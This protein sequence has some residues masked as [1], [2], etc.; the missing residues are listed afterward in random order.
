M[1]TASSIMEKLKTQLEGNANLSYVS[2]VF[3][4]ARESVTLFPALFIEPIRNEETSESLAYQRLTLTVAILGY[5]SVR[6]VDKQIV[7]DTKT[8]GIIDLENDIKKAVSSDRSLGGLAIDT[9]IRQSVYG[10]SEHPARSIS[11][12][13][14]IDYAQDET[15]RA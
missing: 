10:R 12:E 15:E 14:D 5:V 1:S 13:I 3:I 7:G 9:R 4:G 6:N 2:G 11:I 8:R